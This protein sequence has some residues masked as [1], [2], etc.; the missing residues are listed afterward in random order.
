M[1]GGNPEG[2][3]QFLGLPTASNGSY[4]QLDTPD[5]LVRQRREDTVAQ[6]AM[7]IMVLDGND[8]APGRSRGIHE[9]LPIDGLHTE[10]IDYANGN[11]CFQQFVVGSERF[12]EGNTAGDHERA[13]V[14]ATAQNFAFSDCELLV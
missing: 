6:P 4:G 5:G 2:F 1:P 13:V 8:N 7:G 10:Q 3:E 14:I 9:F 11:C 12:E